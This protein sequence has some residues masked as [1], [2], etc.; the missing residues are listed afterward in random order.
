MED[1]INT[2]YAGGYS[3]DPAAMW[4]GLKEQS[5][6]LTQLSK[7]LDEYFALRSFGT[8]E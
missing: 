7:E 3:S 5:Q 2:G 1:S 8:T 6:M 4:N